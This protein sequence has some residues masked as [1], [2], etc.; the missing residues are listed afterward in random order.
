MDFMRYWPSLTYVENRGFIPNIDPPKNWRT[1]IEDFYKNHGKEK[2]EK[3]AQRFSESLETITGKPEISLRWDK[4]DGLDGIGIGM[5]QGLYLENG[6][7][8]E[9]N[10]GTRS[11]LIATGIL[12]NYYD[13]LSKYIK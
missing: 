12:L 8:Q 2:I 13:E 6:K 4:K 1:G 7:W 10:L 11:S 9:H 3:D 5:Q